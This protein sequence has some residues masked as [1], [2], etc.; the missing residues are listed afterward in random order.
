MKV[1]M[2]GIA[3][4][5]FVSNSACTLANFPTTGFQTHISSTYFLRKVNFAKTIQLGLGTVFSPTLCLCVQLLAS[6]M[7]RPW[8][9]LSDMTSL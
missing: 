6:Y 7:F 8:K 5:R 2:S 3:Q 9:C 4:S 1:R